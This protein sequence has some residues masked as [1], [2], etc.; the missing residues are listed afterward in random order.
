M[1]YRDDSGPHVGRVAPDEPELE[2]AKGNAAMD[3]IFRVEIA[4]DALDEA[5]NGARETEDD[6]NS[7]EY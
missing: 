1:L 4:D 3:N 7:N 6:I 5:D 2:T